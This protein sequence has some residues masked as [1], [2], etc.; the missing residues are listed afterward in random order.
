MPV[1][2][3]LLLAAAAAPPP[4]PAGHEV[5]PVTVTATPTTA[6]PADV[7]VQVDSDPEGLKDGAVSIWPAQAQAMGISG[8]VTL[9]CKVDI[10]GLAETCRVAAED[11][12]GRGFGSAALAL[13][14]TFKLTPEMGRDGPEDSTKTIA[15]EFKRKEIDTNVRQVANGMAAPG[16]MKPEDGASDHSTPRYENN[17][18]GVAIFHNPVQTRRV[19]LMDSRSWA[20]APGFDELAAAYPAEGGG[21]EGYAVA[22]CKMDLTGA[23]NHCMAA[24]EFPTGH[25][26][27]KA[28]VALAPRFR[29]SAAV[30]AS[31]PK[32]APV[33]ADVPIRFPPPGEAKDHTV[34]APVWA[35]GYDLP[36][37]LHDFNPPGARPTSPGSQVKCQVAGDGALTA[38]ETELTSPD[39]LAYDRAAVELASKLRM[40]LWSA[41]AGP[42][43]GG[44]VHI[45]IKRDAGGG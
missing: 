12:P 6:P 16:P 11:P 1:L 10:H 27:G 7:T 2:L 37:L 25:G 32:G 31:A 38:C 24:K 14:P 18:S 17:G 35:A 36:T 30:M 23:L 4:Q 40:T 28:A 19:T 8:H 29:V 3:F 44:V 43:T 20:S 39:G 9:S 34:R 15:V 26:F 42:V 22:H 33:E 13:R 5:A 41:E 45:V 21:I